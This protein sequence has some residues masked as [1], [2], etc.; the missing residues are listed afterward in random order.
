MIGVVANTSVVCVA[1]DDATLQ[2]LDF[3]TGWRRISPLVLSAPASRLSLN[4]HS[5]FMVVTACGH[6]NV[7]DL[8]KSRKLVS[9]ESLL[10]LMNGVSGVF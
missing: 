6:M 2:I 1:L 5:I 9:N 4:V 8:I 7:W 10:P 3:K